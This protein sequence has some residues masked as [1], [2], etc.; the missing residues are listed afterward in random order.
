MNYTGK[1]VNTVL[2]KGTVL[3]K[4]CEKSSLARYVVKLDDPNRWTLGDKPCFFIREMELIRND[5]P[6]EHQRNDN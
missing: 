2:G 4:E 3:R 1:R 6:N 5:L